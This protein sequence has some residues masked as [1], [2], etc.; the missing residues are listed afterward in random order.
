MIDEGQMIRIRFNTNHPKDPTSTVELA[1]R[2]LIGEDAS[3]SAEKLASDVRFNVPSFSTH[4]V[5]PDVGHKWHFACRG[6]PRWEGT[7]FIVDAI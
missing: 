6:K 4:E 2:I 1:W 5:L 3:E 7:V